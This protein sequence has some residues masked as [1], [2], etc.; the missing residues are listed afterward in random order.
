MGELESASVL[1]EFSF[2]SAWSA[3]PPA[4]LLRL[5]RRAATMNRRIGVTGRLRLDGARF[6]QTMEGPAEV[7]LSLAGAILADPRHH[8]IRVTAFGALAARR[9]S[10]WRDEGFADLAGTAEGDNLCR[11]PERIEQGRPATA[12]ILSIGAAG[13]RTPLPGA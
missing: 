3:M 10:D 9:F 4:A 7:V 6:V 5:A 13:G 8:A 2:E 1:L 12:A 11:L